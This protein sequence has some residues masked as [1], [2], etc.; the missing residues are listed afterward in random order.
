[1]EALLKEILA[2]AKKTNVRIDGLDQ[3]IEGLDQKVKGLDQKIEGLD[4]KV[5]GLDQKMVSVRSEVLKEIAL[6][7]AK[8]EDR[9]N[10]LDVKIDSEISHMKVDIESLSETAG[11]QDI[12]IKRLQKMITS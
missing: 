8:M 3:K 1:M 12:Q 11:K 2:E 5:E 10:Q 6:L 7:E 4:Q 9:F